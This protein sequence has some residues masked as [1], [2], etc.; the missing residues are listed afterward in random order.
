MKITQLRQLIREEIESVIKDTKT[1]EMATMIRQNPSL[2][3]EKSL[4][5]GD[6]IMWNT[7]R[8]NQSG[9]GREVDNTIMGKVV[10]ILGSANV[11]AE[12]IK[13]GN[14]FKVSFKELTRVPNKGDRIEA[15]YSY[16]YG[17]GSGSQGSNKISGIVTNVNTENKMLT[18]KSEESGKTGKFNISKLKNIKIY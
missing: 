16:D 18:L 17:V 1:N 13:T 7:F 6:L 11:Q 2:P 12:D 10:K 8:F 3:S 9:M 5:V 14:L 4:Q 15:V